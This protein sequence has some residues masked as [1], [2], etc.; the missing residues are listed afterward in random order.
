M[1]A[2]RLAP[3]ERALLEAF[4]A[5]LTR[6]DVDGLTGWVRSC[7]RQEWVDLRRVYV[8]GGPA[9]SIEFLSRQLAEGENAR[10][11]FAAAEV[12]HAF[13]RGLQ[14][15]TFYDAVIA[16]EEPI[17]AASARRII[18]G[19]SGLNETAAG[20]LVP[21]ATHAAALHNRVDHLLRVVRGL[22]FRDVRLSVMRHLLVF[23][24]L[25]FFDKVTQLASSGEAADIRASLNALALMP[26]LKANERPVAC[27]WARAFVTHADARVSGLAS[28]L[29]ARCGAGYEQ[30]VLREVRAR[31]ARR[32]F[33]VTPE[34]LGAL[35]EQ[36][37][38][39][40]ASPTCMEA[41]ALVAQ[42][43]EDSRTTWTVRAAAIGWG[44]KRRPTLESLKRLRRVEKSP[45]PHLRR[46]AREGLLWLSNAHGLRDE[47]V[48]HPP[49]QESLPSWR[50]TARGFRVGERVHVLCPPRGR[51]GLVVGSGPYAGSSSVCSAA[52]HAGRIETFLG[53]AVTFRGLKASGNYR[54]SEKHGVTSVATGPAS[55]LNFEVE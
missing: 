4:D 55:L 35:G 17:G 39:G 1:P 50:L 15:P 32:R 28:R 36:C 23:K 49:A 29:M 26:A 44:V 18:R 9:R 25:A 46:A 48:M 20:H 7:P 30:V 5:V 11:N 31:L 45:I 12:H 14:L 6:C 19:L 13:A 8:K 34:L 21:A 41:Q 24:R 38:P 22:P 52:V 53:G 54:A 37:A 16:G 2:H 10:K 51:L 3:G 42:V 27:P 33:L 47:R 43:A 40:V